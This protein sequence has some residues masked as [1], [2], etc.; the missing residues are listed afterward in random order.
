MVSYVIFLLP[1]IV[2]AVISGMLLVLGFSVSALIN[3]RKIKCIMTC[4]VAWGNFLFAI[5]S[6]CFPLMLIIVPA[7]GFSGDIGSFV[8]AFMPIFTV[9]M[10]FEERAAR[11]GP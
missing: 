11:D 9:G 8:A 1:W 3:G 5:F 2:A 7:Y 6:F 10:A 4:R